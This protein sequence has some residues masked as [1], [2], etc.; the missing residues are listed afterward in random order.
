MKPDWDDAPEWAQ[1]LAQDPDGVWYWTE[2]EPL[3][4]YTDTGKDA[5]A[6]NVA[7]A[8]L[9][10]RALVGAPN[11]NWRDTL[12]RRQSPGV[13]DTAIELS[14]ERR[15]L[16]E[17]LRPLAHLADCLHDAAPDDAPIP[18]AV[19]NARRA[20]DLLRELGEWPEAS[21][22]PPRE[23]ILTDEERETLRVSCLD[24]PTLT[25][26][27]LIRAGMKAEIADAICEPPHAPSPDDAD[28][29]I[30]RPSAEPESRETIKRVSFPGGLGEP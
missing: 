5:D 19:G 25:R 14:K 24:G 12:E 8:G 10:D 20:R 17:A 4:R 23:S 7:L 13:L 22:Q 21:E 2:R 30:A 27:S 26:D 3:T 29:M 1:W 15:L 18:I 9:A 6:W 11:P 16:I 28:L